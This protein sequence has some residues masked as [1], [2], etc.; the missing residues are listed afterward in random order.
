MPSGT[1][2]KWSR[3]FPDD[4]PAHKYA[5]LGTVVTKFVTKFLNRLVHGNFQ[6]VMDVLLPGLPRP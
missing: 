6:K 5:D 3:Q 4:F 2:N 1:K